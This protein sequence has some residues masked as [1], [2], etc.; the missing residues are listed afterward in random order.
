MAIVLSKSS[1][2][3]I[4]T[5]NY[6]KGFLLERHENIMSWLF[7]LKTSPQFRSEVSCHIETLEI[8]NVY[9]DVSKLVSESGKVTSL[10][11]IN[12]SVY[13]QFLKSFD[14]SGELEKLYDGVLT[15]ENYT[16]YVIIV[17]LPMIAE[18]RANKRLQQGKFA[19]K[20]HLSFRQIYRRQNIRCIVDV[21][22]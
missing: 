21:Y 17:L 14:R 12:P 7:D 3:Y 11:Y 10:M 1:R 20:A 5:Q 4:L 16:W 2:A 19:S 13:I 15:I 8:D 6:L 18:M 9:E 22:R